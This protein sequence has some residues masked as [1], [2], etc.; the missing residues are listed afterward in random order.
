[1][2][3]GYMFGYRFRI[4]MYMFSALFIGLD[5]LEILF[6]SL[7]RTEN[8]KWL[9][10][11]AIIFAVIIKI[12]DFGGFGSFVALLATILLFALQDKKAA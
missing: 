12:F 7:F 2:F 9:G 1:M 11:L 10:V 6:L 3:T 5:A 4:P 8:K